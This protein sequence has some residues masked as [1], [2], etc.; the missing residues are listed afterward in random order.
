MQCP[1]VLGRRI[2]GVDD[3]IN[4]SFDIVR[5]VER[6]VRADRQS[7]RTIGSAFWSLLCSSKTVS[8]ARS[9]SQT[10]F[11]RQRPV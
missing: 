3:S 6:P 1:G 8:K 2:A 7:S 5:N 10:A 4:S 9:K 11:T